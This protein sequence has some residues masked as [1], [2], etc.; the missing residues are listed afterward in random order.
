MGVRIE[1]IWDLLE[2]R[3]W[4]SCISLVAK[5]FADGERP[6]AEKA[7][8]NFALCR[9]YSN[10][11]AYA[12]ALEPGQ[13]AVYLSEQVGDFNLL[14]R[15]LIEL[16]W[17]QHR[18]PG[19]EPVAVIT[20]RRYFREFERY[21][22]EARR[23]YLPAMFN[24]AVYLRSAGDHQEA[25]DQFVATYAAAQ[26]RK[27][28]DLADMARR[29]AAWQALHL[30]NTTLAADLIEQGREYVARHGSDAKTVS[31]HLLNESKLLLLKGEYMDAAALAIDAAVA[32]QAVAQL[33]ADAFDLLHQVGKATG[34][35]EGALAFAIIAK[36]LAEQ[37]E[38]PDMVQRIR[39]SVREMAMRFPD[40]VARFM[41]D[42]TVQI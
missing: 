2:Q 35:I 15:S 42:L 20:Q 11:D 40:A 31:N 17:A 6:D 25:L 1:T 41:S 23:Q 3:E 18:V 12:S 38:R 21:G 4:D 37:N 14:S 33:V 22:E 27:D 29:N 13:L 32:G 28:V 36:H 16:A 24:L 7:I 8:L 19:M 34:E 9:S 39:S 30:R 26:A 5:A 10:K